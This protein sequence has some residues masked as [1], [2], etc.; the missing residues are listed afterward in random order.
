MAARAH[1]PALFWDGLN[2]NPPVH[3]EVFPITSPG[4]WESA[5]PGSRT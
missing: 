4:V 1:T 2:V 5:A 3:G